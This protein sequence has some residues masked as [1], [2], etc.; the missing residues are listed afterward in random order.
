MAINKNMS[1]CVAVS[2][3]TLIKAIAVSAPSHMVT[4]RGE[5]TRLTPF[6]K[7]SE[8]ICIYGDLADAD[9]QVSF[10]LKPSPNL[11][12]E[13]QHIEIIGS[14]KTSISKNVS[15]F[16]VHIDGE[17]VLEYQVD[18][19]PVTLLN[20]NSPE[21][22]R[23]SLHSFLQNHP[24]N[25]LYL[26]T[27]ETGLK[28]FLSGAQ[29][30]HVGKNIRYEIVKVNSKADI[31][32][33]LDTLKR[34]SGIAGLGIIRGGGATADLRLWDD[35]E[36]VQQFLATGLPY[37]SAVGHSDKLLLI[38]KYSM[39][40]FPVPLAFG[41]AVG[42]ILRDIRGADDLSDKN[43]SLQKLVDLHEVNFQKLEINSQKLKKWIW[44]LSGAMLVSTAL[45]FL[46]I[47]Y[48]HKHP[49]LK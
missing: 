29:D 32:N 27:T 25:S 8:I 33:C 44:R 16:N 3:S 9:G 31:L 1:G 48:L 36:I 7:G 37:Y 15:G 18:K 17:M 45:F 11:K 40:S 42:E 46:I 6:T 49:M 24:L 20:G 5:V 28:D 22:P 13:G 38:D 43:A 34:K 47:Y 23:T 14:V 4:V 30:A 39:E 21:Q 19:R 12:G 41:H 35:A 2:P 26:I 10:K